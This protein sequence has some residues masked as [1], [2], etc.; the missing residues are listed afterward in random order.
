MSLKLNLKYIGPEHKNMLS[1]G[2]EIFF[3][4]K[5]TSVFIDLT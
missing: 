3:T 2:V 4:V 5:L 1:F